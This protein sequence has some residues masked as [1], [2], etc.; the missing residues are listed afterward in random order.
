MKLRLEVDGEEYSLDLSW[1]GTS[2]KYAL[3]GSISQSGEGSVAEVSPGVFSVLIRGKVFA[4]RVIQ[5]EDELEVWT[6]GRR[7]IISLADLRDRSGSKKKLAA[8]GPVDIRAQ[9]PGKVI[10]LLVEVG[11]R[12][13]AGQGIIVVEAMKM[14]NEMKS[15]KDGVITKIRAAEGATVAAGETLVVIE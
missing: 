9:M 3:A 4:V 8:A 10:K 7:R 14:Q 13:Q 1:N 5:K 15:P 2:A 11:A 6:G 12:V